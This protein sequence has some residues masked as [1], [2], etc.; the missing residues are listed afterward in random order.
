[1]CCICPQPQDVLYTQYT[2]YTTIYIT[3]YVAIYIT[4]YTHYIYT[5]QD[6]PRKGNNVSLSKL[7]EHVLGKPLDKGVRMTD[8][9]ARPLTAA[10]VR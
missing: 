1:M 2:I 6:V 10:Q 5:S 7:C 9:E 4:T 8:W 3:T